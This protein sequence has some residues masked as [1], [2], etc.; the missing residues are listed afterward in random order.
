MNV[1]VVIPFCAKDCTLASNL[2]AWI[3][4]LGK[5]PNNDCLLIC[6]GNVLQADSE[7]VRQKASEIFKSALLIRP[8]ITL[9]SEE[10]PIGANLMFETAT[11]Y[12]WKG[13]C[14]IPWLWLEPDAVPLDERWLTA[15]ETEY[16]S[17]LK[18]NRTIL[19]CMAS[20]N[21]PRYPKAIP[22]GVAV[23]PGN[24][25]A[26]YKSLSLNRK[27]AWDIQFAN[28]VAGTVQP[29]A[30]IWNR[31]NRQMAPTYVPRRTAKMPPNAIVVSEFPKGVCLV[32]PCKD[33]SLT[34]VLRGDG[35]PSA[36]QLLTAWKMAKECPASTLQVV[37]TECSLPRYIHCVERHVQDG[38]DNEARVLRAFR[39][40]VTLY[41]MGRF[42]PCHVWH[43]PR[44]SG[45]MGDQRR[46]PYLKDIL[47]EG[48]TLAKPDDVIVFTNDDTVLHSNIIAALDKALAKADAVSS[49]R[50]N[51]PPGGLPKL[52]AP[53]EDIR[54]LGKPD[55]GRD[56]MALK[57]QW[58]IDNWLNIPD[59]LLGELEWDLVL[60][61]MIRR[62]AGI[63]TD[64]KN[65]V[66]PR[67]ECELPRG[68]VLHETHLRPWVSKEHKA[69]PSKLWNRK[70]SVQW[71]SANNF[72]SLIPTF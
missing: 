15:I 51:F 16:A 44:H 5:H 40:W 69:S 13:D 58:L 28:P 10:H 57:K 38:P 34:S 60:T 27:V 46:L 43:Y 14:Q 64:R 7:S 17:A 70:L 25:F 29:A 30:T 68:Y 23:Y 72:S 65:I 36:M 37:T 3:G 20:L 67:L 62:S 52:D 41:K 61:A 2:L 56:L 45:Q 53:E 19:A 48:M 59:F 50:L 63:H 49:F 9:K 11:K 66:E 39:S 24:A 4:E 26:L 12:F 32:H 71:Y 22:S 6:A 1:T 21:D 31:L 8:A 55:L 35:E 33:G 47:V 18:A 54:K 42:V